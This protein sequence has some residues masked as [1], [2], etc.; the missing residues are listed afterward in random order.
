[1]LAFTRIFRMRTVDQSQRCFDQERNSDFT[2]A[3]SLLHIQRAPRGES[4]RLTITALFAL[5]LAAAT[6]PAVAQT[7]DSATAAAETDQ[8]TAIMAFFAEYD[9]EQLARSPLSKSYRSIKDSD[10]GE[11]DDGSEEAESR[12]MDAERSALREM[13]ARFDST[14]LSPENRLSYRLFEKRAARGEA[15][16]KYNDY[17]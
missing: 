6:S 16:F 1:M 3:Q 5:A 2:P 17:G 10:Y 13:K 11:W 7:P 4:L 8:N 14:K 9:A 15:A 12:A